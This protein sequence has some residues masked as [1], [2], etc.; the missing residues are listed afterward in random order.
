MKG[1]VTL[2][3]LPG[4][5]TLG[6]AVNVTWIANGSIGPVK[7]EYFDGQAWST[8]TSTA[9]QNG[10]FN[11][12]LDSVNGIVNV[13]NAAKVR[14]TDAD[15]PNVSNTSGSFTVKALVQ[16]T[17]PVPGND[18]WTVD[19]LTRSITWNKKGDNI[20]NVKIEYDTIAGNFSGGQTVIY[21]S[22][23]NDG[24]QAWTFAAGADPASVSSS[25]G[26]PD[27]IRSGK[28]LRV[29]IS[30]LPTTDPWAASAVSAGFQI[31][32]QV[33]MVTPGDVTGIKWKIGTT[34]VVTWNNTHGSTANVKLYYSTA[35][36][37]GPWALIR[38][39]G[40]DIVSM[41][42]G[43]AQQ[44]HSYAWDIP[45]DFPIV[46]DNFRLKVVDAANAGI[47]DIATAASSTLSKFV[48]TAPV[49]GN[50]WVAENSHT[51]QW[52]TAQT[53][54]PANVLIEYNVGAGWLPI[55]ENDGTAND[56]IVPNT[57]AKSWLLPPDRTA[58]AKIR[59]S[60]PNDP[61]STVESDPFKIRGD[62]RVTAP[63]IGTEAWVVT[64]LNDITW[65]KKGN[66]SAVNLQITKDADA[67]TVVWENLVDGDSKPTQN[68]DVTGPGPTYTFSWR[69]PDQ[70]DIVSS[71]IKIRVVDAS[72]PT[73]LDDSDNKFTVQ[74]RINLTQAVPSP[75]YVADDYT[76]TWTKEG[77]IPNVKV[78]YSV[79]GGAY[80]LALDG[81]GNPANN[82]SGNSFVWRI[83]DSISA[84]IVLR[85]S[86]VDP[87]KPTLSAVSNA[88]GV[89]GKLALGAPATL[90]EKLEVDSDYTV[91]WTPTGTLN[92]V[93]LEYSTNGFADESQKFPVLGPLGQS[94]ANLPAGTS[95]QEQTFTWRIPNNISSTVKVRVT[96]N[97]DAA[98][99]GLSPAVKI[100]GG[101]K[102]L[103]PNGGGGAFYEV[104]GTTAITWEKHGTIA[105]AQ[106]EYSTNGFTNES[107][108]F[109]IATVPA[110]DLSYTWTIPDKIGTNV[111]VRI[112]DPAAGNFTNGDTSD[113]AFAVRGK[114]DVTSPVNGD[115]WLIA[116]DHPVTFVKHGT[117]PSVKIEYSIN[118]G[119]Y[120]YVLDGSG[121]QASGVAGTSF[122][123]RVPDQKTLL[124]ARIKVSNLADTANVYTVT[125]PFTIRGG[126]ALTNPSAAGQVFKV[127]TVYT[128]SWTTFG[129]IPT[130]DLEYSTNNGFSY[131][132]LKDLSNNDATAISNTGTFNW[133]VPNSIS[134]DVFI[135]I[136]DSTDSDASDISPKVKI[137]GT[138]FLDTP[139]GASRWGV[140][141]T[142][143][144][145]WHTAGSIAN[146]K[147]E[148]SIDGGSSW[149]TPAIADSVVAS[150][151]TK[152]WLIPNTVT[153]NA[154]IRI[155]DVVTDAGTDPVLS[156]SF[157][158][159]GSFSFVA[160]TAGVTWPVS[161]GEI[162]A[163]PQNI[164][165]ATQG[166]VASVN[167]RYSSTGAAPWALINTSGPIADG[168]SGGS[169]SWTVP[170]NISSTVKILIEDSSDSQ[171]NLESPLFTISGDLKLTSPVGG[172]KWGVNSIQTI[173]WQR[174]GSVSEVYLFYSKNGSAGPWIGIQNPLNGLYNLP[175]SGNFVWTVPDDM[176]TQARV[177]ITNVS[178][179]A[180][181]NQSAANFKIMARYDVTN[182]D[183]GEIISAGQDY[184]INWN[185]WGTNATNV[186]IELSTNGNAGSPT[187]DKVI[188][189]NTANNGTFTWLANA[190]VSA[191]D[192]ITP[193]AR[194]RISDVNDIDS[195]NTSASSFL[196]RASF[197][198][199]P[200]IGSV[201]V[202]AGTAYDIVWAKQGNIPN[203]K[204]QYSPDNFFADVRNI[205][206]TPDGLVPN[207]GD[208]GKGDGPATGR[209]VWNVPDIEAAKADN[210]K[211]RIS[212]PND[213][214]ANAVSNV[215]R[216]VPKFTVTAPNGNA[217]ASLTDKLK[218]GQPYTITWTSTSANDG[219][220]TPSVKISYSTNGGG[221]YNV[222][223]TTENDGSY[224]WVT[225]NGGVPDDISSQ[226]KIRVEDASDN[227]AYDDSDYNCKIISNFTLTAPNGGTVHEVTDPYT[228]TW[229]KVGTAASVELSY[230]TD[231]FA[232][233]PVVILAGT[234]ND[235]SEAWPGGFPDAVNYNVKVRVRSLTDDGY[236]DSDAVFR[237]R[238]K[239]AVT[240]PALGAPVPIGQ[241]YNVTWTTT[242]TIPNVTI[243]YDVNDGNGPD[244][245]PDTGD[246][247][248]Y[249]IAT[250]IPNTNSFSWTNIPDTGTAQARIKIFD[251]RTSPDNTDVIGVSQRFNIV[252]NFIL[253]T[254][255]GGEDWRVGST[256]NI[257]WKWGGTIPKVRLL[258]SKNPAA[259]PATIPDGDWIEIDPAVDKSYGAGN[260]NNGAVTR[261]YA[262][263]V[264]DDLSPSVRVMV[265][266]Y[267]DASVRD[268]SDAT[269]KING[270]L[271]LTAP[272]G[273]ADP[274]LTDRWVTSVY[275][276]NE[277][278]T[279]T[280]NTVGSVQNV[281]IQYS[282][283]NFASNVVDIT[284]SVANTGS[285]YWEVPDIVQKD[286]NGKYT[287]PTMIKIRV[288]DVND[289]VVYSQ[290]NEPIKI[291]YYKVTW[292]VRDLGTYSLI[293]E[294]NVQESKTSDTSFIQ[295]LENAIP[296][297]QTDAIGPPPVPGYTRIEPTPAGSWVALWTKTGYGDLPQGVI[298]VKSNTELDPTF[299]LL[300]ETTVIHI[301]R[302]ESRYTYDPDTK[303]LDITAWRER[304]G[305]L[306][307]GTLHSEVDLYD[308]STFLGTAVLTTTGNSG[309]WITSLSNV[310]QA[311]W[312]IVS[313]KTYTAIARTQNAA[314][315]PN[316]IWTATATTFEITT[317]SKLEEV[318]ATIAANIDKPLSAISA[319]LNA[320]LLAQTTTIQSALDTQSQQINTKLD[321]QTAIIQQKLDDFTSTIQDSIVKLEDASNL[322]LKSAKTLEETALKFS[323]KAVVAPNPALSGDSILLQAQGPT[324]LTPYL[325]V[326][327][328]QNKQ[329]IANGI[330]EE[331]PTRP[332]NY[333][334]EFKANSSD[335]DPGQAYTYI[336][337]ED[338][339]GGLVAGSGFVE[340]ISLT[341]VAGLASAAPAAE[342]A[343]KEAV[344]AIKELEATMAKGGD[345][346]SALKSLQKS[347]NELPQEV[348][349][350]S[351]GDTKR[352]RS[353]VNEISERLQ[354]LAGNE[355]LDLTQMI[356][357]AI[358]E[359]SSIQDIRGRS[360]AISQSLELLGAVVEK[361]LG[362]V[363]EPVVA[364]FFES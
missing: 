226:V 56:G 245:T 355:G 240:S 126:F 329:V 27:N 281:K 214:G 14:I 297:A 92:T 145:T 194:I 333:N 158:I 304:D 330:M 261:S 155:S 265:Q 204:I 327:N 6:D 198:F 276:I 222:I 97:A 205:D 234:A 170:D 349:K 162:P 79:S 311:P 19:D 62:L 77:T 277:G 150:L 351:G 82:V 41:P 90:N 284:P 313:G 244:L 202:Q 336:V 227:T 278:R 130:I 152:S 131:S 364:T 34:N 7:V 317:P 203:V 200:T 70:S 362:G 116:S 53:G 334:F 95:G 35:G 81:V 101:L 167:L 300:M 135:R 55:Q 213:S 239:L 248:P 78:E 187:Y 24:S 171:T 258:Y 94:A 107:E 80:Q 159:V 12:V 38:N 320:S 96:N 112:V 48:F 273:N 99:F 210:L 173:T 321:Q 189:S 309:F 109:P 59:I 346:R 36:V 230:S 104:D 323:W 156:P 103:T 9:P 52:T 108:T 231:N 358:D 241:N 73:V 8:I 100:V 45:N 228:I 350:V 5:Y 328:H 28:D 172:E 66:M 266:D 220:H 343:A 294:L 238:G 183:G 298:L 186:K 178:G 235:G 221:S 141:S 85:V 68:L 50:V 283:D 40:G 157:K 303:R 188:A 86:N 361:R 310:D 344:E 218:V 93:K 360:E 285:F 18:I 201:P 120:S 11:L 13:T 236:D 44:Q 207:V 3:A 21:A 216:V 348:A 338:V 87:A 113:S 339:T 199:S 168:G 83:P 340:S 254:P 208:P 148:Y 259:D 215:F 342:K 302:T 76:V 138:L 305:A 140:G 154:M 211:F 299:T 353:T 217:T 251:S 257:T 149:V 25:G 84:N 16:I 314:Q 232:T 89:K 161:V 345:M 315:A 224:D 275:A 139:T 37:N 4:P 136:K 233:A 175:N 249:A 31:I 252:G 243:K 165:W 15:D 105:Q 271:T 22:T 127:G 295:W 65:T 289:P 61:D 324:G 356:G 282:T 290:S 58:A 119:S 137:A 288:S 287:A 197:V 39:A 193:A 291:D 46:K 242:G 246:E 49:T 33:D 71:K 267:N 272:L 164:V 264:P 118:N 69:V 184:V 17:S 151:G 177:R 129:T 42:S 263:V 63:N 206:P 1:K 147:I 247:Y 312:N 359:N 26:I 142:Q 128:L 341:A 125:Q 268:Y 225:G 143:N 169:Y 176:T 132:P 296:I 91:R 325:S 74:G 60:D 20:A 121:G 182:P 47:E 180:I 292:I 347:V 280:W 237:I 301:T 114:I 262:W 331:D 111:K 286:G 57:G 192:N 122:T 23:A 106:I 134:K 326:Y 219:V 223:T 191:A 124:G 318:R 253:Q 144:V 185:R 117:M 115:V 29:R 322:S 123:W 195:A 166:S 75:Q 229:T 255:N 279:I 354:K 32:G 269:F 337:T 102:I 163:G 308:G 256:H 110:N 30:T 67:G 332:G 133:N 316:N 363:D 10:P 64:T 306:Q 293:P 88:F 260:G 335:F 2:N 54:V 43:S 209:Y 160:P 98:V 357:K 179:P 250:N 146:V 196:I 212:D 153:P 51:I 72:D 270:T 352:I 174:N 319:E 274:S 181:L 190:V 307:T